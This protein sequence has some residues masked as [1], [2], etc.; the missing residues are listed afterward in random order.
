[1]RDND[2]TKKRL[3]GVNVGV[4]RS[5]IPVNDEDIDSPTQ[6]DGEGEIIW[7]LPEQQKCDICCSIIYL[8]CFPCIS[9]FQLFISSFNNVAQKLE[10]ILSYLLLFCPSMPANQPAAFPSRPVFPGEGRHCQIVS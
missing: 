1:M 8:V 5:E 3:V 9:L 6:T 2:A 7:N 4:E 10:I